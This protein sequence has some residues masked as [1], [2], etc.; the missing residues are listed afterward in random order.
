MARVVHIDL[1]CP[2][3]P[4]E[5]LALAFGA[6][7]HG[8][9][10]HLV[11]FGGLGMLAGSATR[12]L[13][14]LLRRG[15][16]VSAP[17]CELSLGLLWAGSGY[18][19]ASGWLP[20]SWLPLSLELGWLVVA[21]GSVDVMHRRLPDALT[22]PALPVALL[23][24]VP[25]GGASVLRALLGAVLLVTA[26]LVVRLCAPASLG[27]GDVKLAGPLGAALGA[28]SWTAL[29]AGALL[30]SL[31][32][33]MLA[34]GLTAVAVLATP[35]VRGAARLVLRRGVPHGPSMLLAGWTVLTVAGA[36]GLGF[37]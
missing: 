3:C 28:A 9:M 23:L 31:C 34:A 15:A 1:T 11:F 16:N 6:A 12:H 20:G 18:G 19:W 2:Q 35:A 26:H 17:W 27:A 33:A 29:L 5:A 7:Q 24:A 13:L 36:G 22:L 32:T 8:R 21:A 25:L 37:A 4:S 10:A 14:P 30:A